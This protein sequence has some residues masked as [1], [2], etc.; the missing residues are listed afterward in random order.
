M[1]LRVAA[2]LPRLELEDLKIEKL[3]DG[4]TEIRGAIRN[5]GY[6]GSFGLWSA[7]K[8]HWNEPLVLEA[9]GRNGATVTQERTELGHVD[10][11]GKG[12][13][14]GSANLFYMRS[15]GN[16]TRRAFRIVARGTGLVVL[17]VAAAASAGWSGRSRWANP[18]HA[19]AHRP[20]RSRT[21]LPPRERHGSL[22]L[23][24]RVLHAGGRVVVDAEG[25]IALVRGDRDHRA[26][27]RASRRHPRAPHGRRADD[28]RRP[29]AARRRDRAVP[30]IKDIAMT[31]NGHTLAALAPRLRAAGLRRVNVSLDS[32]D[33][34]TF[35]RLTRGGDVKRVLLG[36]EAARTAGLTPIKLNAVVLRGE[37]DHEVPEI[38]DY[39]SQWANDTEVRFI[40][41]MPF[42]ERWHQNVKSRELRERL[43][44]RYTLVQEPSPAGAGPARTWRIRETGCSSASSRRC[45]SISARRATGCGS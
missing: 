24:L 8:R 11:W 29:R 35:G 21:Q 6:L 27:V 45:P 2:L 20:I 17:R 9:L 25:R 7:M 38:V 18:G 32:L 4:V 12:R 22:Q 39:F 10:G 33:P 23:P 5:V 30:G 40:E 42:E 31:T 26:R 13:F 43:E 15:D 41:Y 3:A 16:A 1:F 19:D 28:A 14:G 36:I 44:Q 37:N 34:K